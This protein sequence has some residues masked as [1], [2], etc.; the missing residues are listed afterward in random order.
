MHLTISADGRA[1]VGPLVIFE[2]KILGVS[3]EEKKQRDK[4]VA[5]LF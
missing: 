1:K 4:R 2:G 5:V 3:V